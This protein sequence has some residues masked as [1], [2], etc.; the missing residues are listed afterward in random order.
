MISIIKVIQ[1]TLVL[2][3]LYGRNKNPYRLLVRKQPHCRDESVS[4]LHGF[5]GIRKQYYHKAQKFVGVLDIGSLIIRRK[6]V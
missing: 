1:D 3:I 5:K 4:A 6:L 2:Y